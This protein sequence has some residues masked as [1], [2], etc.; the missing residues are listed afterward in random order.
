MM[1]KPA[2]QRTLSLLQLFHPM[3][4]SNL[5]QIIQYFTGQRFRK[6]VYMLFELY[7]Y[8]HKISV[9]TLLLKVKRWGSGFVVGEA[10]KLQEVEDCP[11]TDS[12]SLRRLKVGFYR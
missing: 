6:I 3:T 8:C 7:C 4:F 10:A 12:G 5:N 1:T 2:P 11:S 9:Q